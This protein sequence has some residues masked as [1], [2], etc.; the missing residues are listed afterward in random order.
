MKVLNICKAFLWRNKLFHRLTKTVSISFRFH[1]THSISVTEL[2]NGIWLWNILQCNLCTFSKI[3]SLHILNYFLL[4]FT[5][6][7]LFKSPTDLYFCDGIRQHSVDLW[8]PT[9]PLFI[10]WIISDQLWSISGK[11]T[12]KE[13]WSTQTKAFS[14]ALYP[15]PGLSWEWISISEVRSQCS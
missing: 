15:P 10:P 11:N 5:S 8:P 3:S 12:N 2:S 7:Y 6:I 9:G 4:H 13:N 14:S 1:K